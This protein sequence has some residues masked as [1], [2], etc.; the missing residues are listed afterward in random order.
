MQRLTDIFRIKT[1]S[2]R[3]CSAF[4]FGE[5]NLSNFTTLLPLFPRY[6]V[7][8]CGPLKTRDMGTNPH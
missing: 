5:L 7:F 4:C 8:D 2:D 1:D 3:I 6:E